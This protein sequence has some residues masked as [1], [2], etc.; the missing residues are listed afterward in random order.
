MRVVSTEQIASLGTA[1]LEGDSAS[2][3]E[4]F[5]HGLDREALVLGAFQRASSVS[6]DPRPMVGRVSGGPVVAVGRGTLHVVLALRKIDALEACTPRQIVNRHVRPLLRALTA[7]GATARFFGRDW[8]DVKSRPTAWV[9]FAHDTTTGRAVLEAFIAVSS[10]F[11]VH[12]RAAYLGKEPGTLDAITGRSFDPPRITAA[13]RAAYE[14]AWGERLAVHMPGLTGSIAPP[15]L[16]APPPPA[17]PPTLMPDEPPW[18][19]TVNEAIGMVAAGR[20]RHGVLRVGG[21]LLASRD[22]LARLEAR[23]IGAAPEAVAA[24]VAEEL[25]DPRVALDGVKSLDSVRDVLV[26]ALSVPS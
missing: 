13:I 1:A 24:I 19:A 6:A 15:P 20:D 8:I 9:G 18:A 25:G 14:A 23:V 12:P 17:V 26:R 5:V 4:L 16:G 3:A 22:A 21:D 10:P 2:D 7:S 11:A